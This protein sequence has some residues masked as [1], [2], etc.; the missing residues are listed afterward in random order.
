[1]KRAAWVFLMLSSALAYNAPSYAQPPAPKFISSRDKI[2]AGWTG[3]VFQLSQD[4]PTTPPAAAAYPW[5]AFDYKTQSLQYITAVLTYCFDG[6]TGIDFVVQNNATRKW[7]H[8]PWLD[9]GANGR[10]FVHGMTH[11][12]TSRPKELAPTQTSPAQNWAVGFYNPV[13]GYTI[14]QVWKDAKNPSA[15]AATFADGSVACKLLF[16]A[17]SVAQVP[18]LKNDVQWQANIVS[19]NTRKV[20]T[21]RLLQIDVAVRDTRADATTGWVYGT[22]VYNGN[23]AGTTPWSRMQNVGVQWGN[24]PTVKT[25]PLAESWINPDATLPKQHLG[26][27]GRLNGPVDNPM[28]GCQSCHS[29]AQWPVKSPMMPA[30]TVPQGSTAWMRWYRD[31]KPGTPFDAGSKSLSTSLQLALGMQNLELSKPAPPHAL[32]PKSVGPRVTRDP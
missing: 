26:W 16:T 13:G 32:G 17:A 15:A 29:T 30:A 7:Y 18:Y 23:L 6:N 9:Y 2:P 12:R 27:G 14:G 8:A 31:L 25:G 21:V 5:K 3:P 28:S 24:D 22:F 11:E 10:E 1:M 19:G 4:Y 20:Q